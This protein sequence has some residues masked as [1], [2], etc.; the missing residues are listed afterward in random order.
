MPRGSITGSGDG[1]GREVT[2]K[3][4]SYKMGCAT[5]ENGEK[6]GEVPVDARGAPRRCGN[7]GD[8]R[9]R[10]FA[11]LEVA[12]RRRKERDG[13]GRG[14]RRRGRERVSV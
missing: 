5:G 3:R 8:E 9:Q 4:E 1:G 7:P 12:I 11:A 2:D 13:G 10:H 14:R 6:G